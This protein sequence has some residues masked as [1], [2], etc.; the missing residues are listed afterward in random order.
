[1]FRPAVRALAR[2]PAP[3]SCAG[4]GRRLISTGPTKSRSWK[5]TVVRLGLAGGAIYYYNT[6]SAFSKEPQCTC[7]DKFAVTA[8]A[9]SPSVS[10]SLSVIDRISR[11]YAIYQ[12]LQL[13]LLIFSSELNSLHP[14]KDP[15]RQ[16]QPIVSNH[17]LHHPQDPRRARR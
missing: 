14:C 15:I 1:M 11:V 17:R 12:S 4:Q 2:A 8:A 3:K 16:F 9:M 6:S 13:T 5:N 10:L 7:C